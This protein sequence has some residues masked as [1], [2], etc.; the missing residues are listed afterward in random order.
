[1]DDPTYYTRPGRFYHTYSWRPDFGLPSEYNC[2]EQ[3][4]D[5]NNANSTA[6]FI[7][8]PED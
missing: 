6:G 4:G 2:E 7:P 3:L 1:V 5:K 8:E